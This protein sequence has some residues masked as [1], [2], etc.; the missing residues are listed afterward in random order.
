MHH[1]I[2]Q[3]HAT[4]LTQDDLDSLSRIANAMDAQPLENSPDHAA[5]LRDIRST[6]PGVR[7][8]LDAYCQERQIDWAI[9]PA[10]LKLRDFR[11]LA[12]DMDSTLINIETVDEIG[13]AVGKK[14]EIAAI[15][16]AAMRGEIADYATSLRQRV[17]LLAGVPLAALDRLY[18]DTLRLNPG[19]EALLT[20]AKAAGLK[21]Q[22][23]TGGFTH[24]TDR[25]K[26]R[27][28]FDRVAANVLGVKDDA[29]DGTLV[30]DI[31]DGAAKKRAVLDFCNDLGCDPG[32]VL[33]IGD[34]ANDLPM[35]HAVGFSVAFHAKPKVREA[36]TAAIDF[37]A[38]DS[39]LNWFE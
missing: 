19:A 38:L 7:R 26:Q 34:G 5:R 8:A 28:G 31:I 36:A 17:A 10:G 18:T 22:L 14:D 9:V 20:A 12:M 1:L 16:L 13:A 33:A 2:V 25:L 23:V 29:L 35:M 21:T 4:P 24:F 37:G 39:L 15:T 3:R 11:L 30:G 32:E 27:L 6:G